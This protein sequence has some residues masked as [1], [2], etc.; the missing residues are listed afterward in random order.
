MSNEI[1]SRHPELSIKGESV[2]RV[3]GFYKDSAFLVNRR[4]QRKLVWDIAEKKSFIDSIIRGY[5]V[6]LVLLVDVE[7][8]AKSAYEILDGMQR[9]NAIMAFIEGEYEVGGKF[10]DLESMARTKQ[11]FDE[12]ILNQREPKLERSICTRIA[13]YQIPL[14][15]YKFTQEGEVDD[16]FIRINSHGKHLSRQELRQAGSINNF[17][18]LVRKLSSSVRGDSSEG[19]ILYLQ[20]MAKISITGKE[21][22]Y[23]INIDDVFWIKENIL[24]RDYLRESR[25][26]ELL[27]DIIS[28]AVM[29]EKP[30]SS[31]S[32]LDEF[33]GRK[34]TSQNRQQ[35]LEDSVLK[36]GPESIIENFQFV[37]DELK[38][39]IEISGDK[40]N[41]LMFD[42]AGLRV[43]RY[44]QTVFLAFHELLIDKEM[45]IND[46]ESLAKSLKGI[47]KKHINIG[48]GGGRWS[49]VER[50]NNVNAVMGVIANSFR[51]RSDDDPIRDTWITKL[52]N[53]LTQ[54]RIEQNVYDFKQGFITLNS[55]KSFNSELLEKIA[56]T[57]SAMSNKSPNS[58][59]YIIIGVCE[60]AKTSDRINE[61]FG[62]EPVKKDE[63][64]ITG[65][66]HEA[67]VNHENLDRYFQ[68]I[69][70]KIR[71]LDMHDGLRQSL[72][73]N[74]R[75]VSYYGK[76]LIV[77]MVSSVGE[78]VP[79]KNKFF[80]RHG[81]HNQEL[82]ASEFASLY[83][84]FA[85]G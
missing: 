71:A 33:Y 37:H 30:P 29:D 43:P 10:F 46:Y 65:I 74:I 58:K 40:F 67:Y 84:V 59:G 21:L 55:E 5:P 20:D 61:L 68:F 25:D 39:V 81:P 19:D 34:I 7:Y 13:G 4:Y 32:I 11:L 69:L 54:S 18:E 36:Y 78:P 44:Y 75:L 48:G 77:F 45:I 3:Y 73:K 24:T 8:E 62:V 6:P 60:N 53:I 16:V 2:E 56:E 22:N 70:E 49:A 57:A 85:K 47:G 42:D 83:K 51:E 1:I 28:Y 9:L 50:R 26:E 66:E 76:S 12:K 72:L 15:I 35:V 27:S 80:V 63:F 52:E 14:S 17:S 23:G 31:S 38:K 82:T 79:Y 41:A 64:L